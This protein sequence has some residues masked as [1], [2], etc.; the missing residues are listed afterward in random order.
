MDISG[1]QQSISGQRLYQKGSIETANE[2]MKSSSALGSEGGTGQ[3][4]VQKSVISTANEF[5]R[6][7]TVLDTTA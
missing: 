1:I 7:G 4:S 2:H 6:K 3:A 5:T